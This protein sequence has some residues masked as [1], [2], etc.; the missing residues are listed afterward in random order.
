MTALATPGAAAPASDENHDDEID[1]VDD[2]DT[3]GDEAEDAG[4]D[5]DASP[6]SAGVDSTPIAMPS[7]EP[8][9]I[10]GIFRGLAMI[11]PEKT[12]LLLAIAKLA[13]GDLRVTVQPPP[14]PDEPAETVLP[15]TVTASAEDL[16]AEFVNAFSAYKPARDYATASAAE[17]AR[18]TKAA[19]D[20]TRLEAEAR[21]KKTASTTSP[22]GA[23]KPSGML[24]VKTTPATA[25]IKVAANDGKTHDVTSGGK[26]TLAVGKATITATLAGHNS[27]LTTVTI[28]N[29]ATET[30]ELELPAC[31][32]S[33]FGGA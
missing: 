5:E 1:D 27:R 6:E 8:V 33:L 12:T 15:L 25:A 22:S 7:L 32:P 17:I 21:R 9:A 31:E 11:I 23:R 4:N 28:A 30:V 24:I 13:N 18:A 10:Q 2:A 19:A 16:D 3:E 14:A 29:G 26:I 20:K